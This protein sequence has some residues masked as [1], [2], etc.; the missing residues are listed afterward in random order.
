MYQHQ[1]SSKLKTTY[2]FELSKRHK[3]DDVSCSWLSC[4]GLQDTVVSVKEFHGFEISFTNSDNNDGHRQLRGINNRL[5]S[6]VQ[7]SDLSICDD[8]QDE[9]LL[10]NIRKH[11]VR[12]FNIKAHITGG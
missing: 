5:P 6:L 12:E 8:Q 9:V 11:P 10:K 4:Q 1:D 2:V 3:L 7:I